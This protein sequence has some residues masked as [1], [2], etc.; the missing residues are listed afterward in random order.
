MTLKYGSQPSA[1]LVSSPKLYSSEQDTVIRDS[2]NPDNFTRIQ[3]ALLGAVCSVEEIKYLEIILQEI[4]STSPVLGLVDG[5]LVMLDLLRSGIPEYVVKN[6]LSEG[7]IGTLDRIDKLCKGKNLS[8][9][10]YIRLPGSSEVVDSVR[11][12]SRLSPGE[13][14]DSKIQSKNR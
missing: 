2:D 9:A 11:S 6:V 13:H 3:G 4:V 1:D 7:F 5:T 12:V 10:S 8:L 14:H